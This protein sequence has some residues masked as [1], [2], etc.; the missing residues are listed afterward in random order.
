M[1][2]FIGKDNSKKILNYFWIICTE[3][4]KIEKIQ[5]FKQF[6]LIVM[7]FFSIIKFLIAYHKVLTKKL[8]WLLEGSK[9]NY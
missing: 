1:Y 2:I 7:H 3:K 4:N 5:K 6:F 8:Y 9:Y